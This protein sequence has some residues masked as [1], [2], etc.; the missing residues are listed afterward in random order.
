[1]YLAKKTTCQVVTILVSA[2][3]P[4]GPTP[5]YS[6]YSLTAAIEQTLGLPVPRLP[7]HSSKAPIY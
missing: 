3:M 1:M 5:F 6:H 2:R 4:A 7:R